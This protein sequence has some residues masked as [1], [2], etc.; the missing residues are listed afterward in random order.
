MMRLAGPG[1]AGTGTSDE[2]G[3]LAPRPRGGWQVGSA[4][5]RRG[6]A[7]EEPEDV[8]EYA[9]EHSAEGFVVRHYTTRDGRPCC[10]QRVTITDADRAQAF[11]FEV[12][13]GSVAALQ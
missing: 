2:M 7:L 9:V 3:D 11:D 5:R 4:F 12:R 6:P 1:W 13:K 8:D 10:I